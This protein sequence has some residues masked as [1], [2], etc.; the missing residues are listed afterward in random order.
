MNRTYFTIAFV[1]LLTA[2]GGAPQ[3]A[4][5]IVNAGRVVLVEVDV[6]AAAE[7]R[8]AAE[9]A[10]EASQSLAEYR[11]TMEP[12][13]DVEAGLRGARAALD[14]M[15]D[16]IEVWD[17]L[18]EGEFA[19]A[20]SSALDAFESLLAVLRIAGVEPPQVLMDFLSTPTGDL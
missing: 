12:H 19:A 15:S 3:V 17:Q 14:A 4:T 9:E 1:A 8:R 11:T 10:L 5:G 16:L 6:L 7:Y 18:A 20:L 13:D 2:C